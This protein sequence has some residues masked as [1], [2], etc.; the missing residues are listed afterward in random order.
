MRLA[1]KVALITGAARGQ[2]AAEARLFLREGASVVFSDIREEEGRA[3]EAELNETPGSARFLRQDVSKAEDWDRAVRTAVEEFG[4]IDILVNNAAILTLET[5]EETTEEAWNHVM[6]V[7]S[8]SVMLGTKAVVPEMRKAGGGSI[9]NIS[10]LSAMTAM[11]WAAAYHASKGAVRI[12][13]KVAAMEF[14]KDKI[15]VNSVHPGAI[16]TPM[17]T[18]NYSDDV[19]DTLDA[20]VPL[21]TI[22][23]P[24]DIAYGV[25]YLGSDE[26]RYVTGIE[27]VIDG[28]LLAQ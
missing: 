17:R 24:D 18:E 16:D 25:L 22:G 21:G 1:G 7:N 5:T 15:R 10:S 28:G 19:L 23:E 3:L 13:T 2:G 26:S 11:P 8:T 12:Y 6:A 14:A 20:R 4:K 9:I 27:L